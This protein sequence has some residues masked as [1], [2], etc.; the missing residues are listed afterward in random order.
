MKKGV[1]LFFLVYF[2]ISISTA[3]EFCELNTTL[4][5]QDPYP[6][7]PGNYVKLVFQVKGVDNSECNDIIFELL[8]DY[9]IEFNSGE[10][11]IR[12][13]KKVDYLK[14]FES[15]ILIPYEVRLNNNA[16]DGSNPIKVKFQSAGDPQ[17][18]KTFD[19]EIED[20]RADFEV[21]VKDYDYSTKELTI[22]ILNI[23]KSDVEALT[24]EIPKQEKIN[25]KGP[26][27]IV[28]GDLDSNE[29]TTADF[30]ATILNG[31]FKL[32]IIYSD[33]INVRRTVEKEVSFDSSYFTGRVADK[34][35]T[36]FSTYIL[37]TIIMVLIIY[38]FYKKSKKKKITHSL[39]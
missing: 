35:T 22:E 20:V 39:K 38:Y 7:V 11:G 21:Y 14:D 24:I 30:E 1:L 28:V 29:Y 13:F 2:M 4:L 19:L 10:S 12:T 5:N 18:S 8:K 15:N 16:L 34:K 31:E 32:K 3:Q 37:G 27:K 36:S 6:A 25:I 9:P 33:K 26:N 23:E 17:F